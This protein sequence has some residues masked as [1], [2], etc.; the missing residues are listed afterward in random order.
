LV[1]LLATQT[2][3]KLSER[4]RLS[5]LATNMLP[6]FDIPEAAIRELD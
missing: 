2:S 1:E 6:Q 3:D 4:W 5:L